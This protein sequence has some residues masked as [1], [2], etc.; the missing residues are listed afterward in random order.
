VVNFWATWCPPCIE[1]I[2]S[3]NRLQAL[4]QGRPFEIISINYAQD[5]STVEKFLQRVDV[6]F[7]VLLDPD[8]NYAKSWKVISFPSTFVIDKQGNIRY[9]VNAAIAW[10]SPELID[11]LSALL[12]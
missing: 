3:L 10:D 2:P 8:G 4:M 5:K 11:K 1:E 9:G 12:D 7:P 6:N